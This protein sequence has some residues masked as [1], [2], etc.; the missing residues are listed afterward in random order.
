[1]Y[2]FLYLVLKNNIKNMAQFVILTVLT[3]TQKREL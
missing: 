2:R 1:M 3:A